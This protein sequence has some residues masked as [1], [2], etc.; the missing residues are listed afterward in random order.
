MITVYWHSWADRDGSPPRKLSSP[1]KSGAANVIHHVNTTPGLEP[2]MII[3]NEPVEALAVRSIV[4]DLGSDLTGWKIRIQ[5]A[6]SKQERR[7]QR[8]EETEN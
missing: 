2:E 3:C 8:R 6:V 5:P 4:R 1:S 7:M